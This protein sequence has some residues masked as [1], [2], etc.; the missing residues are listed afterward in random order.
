MRIVFFLALITAT[1]FAN[2][3]FH[4]TPEGEVVSDLTAEPTSQPELGW[5]ADPFQK[6]PGYI[7]RAA[8]PEAFVLQGTIPEGK[9]S[10]AVVNERLVR[11]G[12]EVNGRRVRKI[13]KDYV[14]LEKGGSV[15]ELG[16]YEQPPISDRSPASETRETTPNQAE[17]EIRIEEVTK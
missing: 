2:P 4:S 14:L 7:I 8:E 16:L 10:S 6:V 3:S 9:E 12:D 13:G 5:S 15:I 17:P 1:S 11:V